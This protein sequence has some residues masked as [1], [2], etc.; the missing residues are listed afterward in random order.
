MDAGYRSSAF[1]DIASRRRVAAPA[2]GLYSL[3]IHPLAQALARQ[4][5][6]GCDSR[7]V[8]VGALAQR[9]GDD[10]RSL[11]R[12]AVLDFARGWWRRKARKMSGCAQNFPLARIRIREKGGASRLCRYRS[13]LSNRSN[14]WGQPWWQQAIHTQ[15]FCTHATDSA[16]P[17]G[18]NLGSKGIQTGIEH[19]RR[20]QF[21][22]RA[23]GA[24]ERLVTRRPADPCQAPI[25]HDRRSS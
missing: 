7:V 18:D 1:C 5:R 8:N 25:L 11:S 22:L 4:R 15:W 13:S 9:V 17:R 12:C 2:I 10:E 24:P 23:S 3:R 14:K 20:R 6:C 16:R 19:R 21:C